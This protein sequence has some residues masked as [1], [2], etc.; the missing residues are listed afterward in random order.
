MFGKVFRKRQKPDFAEAL[1]TYGRERCGMRKRTLLAGLGPNSFK[2]PSVFLQLGAILPRLDA[3]RFLDA[4]NQVALIEAFLA[5]DRAQEVTELEIGSNLDVAGTGQRNY[6]DAIACL[7]GGKLPQLETL[8]LGDMYRTYN[9]HPLYG[10]VGDLTD[11]LRACPNLKTLYICGAFSLSAP[12]TMPELESLT[13]LPVDEIAGYG[14]L[15]AQA[16][17]THLLTSDL[18]KLRLLDFAGDPDDPAS[19][20]LPTTFLSG[21]QFPSLRSL[22]M[23]NTIAGQLDALAHLDAEIEQRSQ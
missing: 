11:A 5:S 16:T 12:L 2:P 6:A 7:A 4:P 9:G 21:E 3:V 1:K 10:S 20:R 17:V 8:I 19:Y 13:I 18:P 15:P 22:R 23:G 14:G